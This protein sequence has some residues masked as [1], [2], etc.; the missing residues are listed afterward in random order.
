MSTPKKTPKKKITIGEWVYPAQP[1]D[2][3][4]SIKN[5]NNNSLQA[6]HE[7]IRKRKISAPG[8][9][10]ITEVDFEEVVVERLDIA[11]KMHSPKGFK[12]LEE[13]RL[14][15]AM[16]SLAE[17]RDQ[18]DRQL[19]RFLREHYKKEMIQALDGQGDRKESPCPSDK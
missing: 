16:M 8:C 12:S 4:K 17:T 18:I 9:E 1:T 7:R 11:E 2:H 19:E 6:I 3:I 10:P 13:A 15:E 14:Y 5:Y